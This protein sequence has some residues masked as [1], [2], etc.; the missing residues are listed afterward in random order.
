MRIRSVNDSTQMTRNHKIFTQCM[1]ELMSI[2]HVKMTVMNVTKELNNY[3]S[4]SGLIP[5]TSNAYAEPIQAI[6]AKKLNDIK[7]NH[8]T[9]YLKVSQNSL[10]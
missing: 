9:L 7:S 6:L 4:R 10:V 1:N 3:V 5:M 2:Y 8:K